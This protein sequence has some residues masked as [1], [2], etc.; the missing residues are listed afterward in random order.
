MILY[1]T[2]PKPT[3]CHRTKC[4]QKSLDGIR[5]EEDKENILKSQKVLHKLIDAEVEAGIP[6]ER[7]AIG[8]FSQ[9]GAMALFSGLTYPKKLGGVFGLSCYL[10]LQKDFQ[11]MVTDSGDANKATKIFMGHG[12]SDQVVKHEFGKM[13]A[14][15]LKDLG[16]D[17]DFKTYPYEHSN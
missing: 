7:I 2:I 6:S 8:G 4:G 1:E 15:K 9:G 17:V 3:A 14:D 10:L 5:A 13:S 11:Q 16:F 12:D